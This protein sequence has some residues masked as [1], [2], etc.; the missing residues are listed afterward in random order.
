MANFSPLAGA[1]ESATS[2]GHAGEIEIL[3]GFTPARAETADYLQFPHEQ[4]APL[5]LR[6]HR[7]KESSAEL[8]VELVRRRAEL[9]SLRESVEHTPSWSLWGTSHTSSSKKLTG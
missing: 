4:A 3:V 5:L 1:S 6:A 7:Q 9:L 2:T 8:E